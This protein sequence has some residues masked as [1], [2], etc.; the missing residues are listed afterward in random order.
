MNGWTSDDKVASLLIIHTLH[1]NNSIINIHPSIISL[2]IMCAAPVLQRQIAA[3]VRRGVHEVHA[4]HSLEAA[5]GRRQ[6]GH[7][8]GVQLP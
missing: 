5:I 7:R 2:P 3:A 6:V 1:T 8:P 4:T